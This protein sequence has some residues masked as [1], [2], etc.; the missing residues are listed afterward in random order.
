MKYIDKTHEL[1]FALELHLA[2]KWFVKVPLFYLFLDLSIVRE[3]QREL[4]HRLLN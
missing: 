1:G 4:G 2:L 3:S